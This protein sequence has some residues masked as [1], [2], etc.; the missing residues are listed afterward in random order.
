ML[1]KLPASIGFGTFLVHSGR[2]GFEVVKHML[3]FTLSAPIA[4]LVIYFGLLAFGGS[5][6]E[7]TLMFWCAILLLFSAGSFLYVATIHIM[8]ETYGQKSNQEI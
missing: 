7:Q 2:I 3:A 4:T 1:H 5:A 6:N 8:P